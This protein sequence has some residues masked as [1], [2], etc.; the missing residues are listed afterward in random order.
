MS[1]QQERLKEYREYINYLTSVM[2]NIDDGKDNELEGTTDMTDISIL[3]D[4]LDIEVESLYFIPKEHPD[5]KT[6]RHAALFF[7]YRKYI[8][9]MGSV[10]IENNLRQFL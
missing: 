10:G 5:F 2:N 3:K 8:Q 7:N 1:K 4:I 6:R 9:L